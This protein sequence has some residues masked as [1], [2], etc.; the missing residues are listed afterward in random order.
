MMN[1][2]THLYAGISFG[3]YKSGTYG[4]AL[5]Q[6]VHPPVYQYWYLHQAQLSDK[7]VYDEFVL[8]FADFLS[9]ATVNG[10]ISVEEF[11]QL[12]EM[13][14]QK[15][16]GNVYAKFNQEIDRGNHV[17]PLPVLI[18]YKSES[19]SPIELDLHQCNLE[20]PSA[21]ALFSF[22]RQHGVYFKSEI[23]DS[24]MQRHYYRFIEK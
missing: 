17:Y 11:L 12:N 23:P 15:E 10:V 21:F 8:K 3:D 13:N 14:N 7:S 6:P 19:K 16:L 24:F 2:T 18:F 22:V 9:R 5:P 4:G 20:G 1:V